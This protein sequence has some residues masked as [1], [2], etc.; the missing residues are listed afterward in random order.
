MNEEIRCVINKGK[1]GPRMNGKIMTPIFFQLYTLYIKKDIFSHTLLAILF[2]QSYV[3]CIANNKYLNKL[4]S[5][6]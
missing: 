4:I 2:K 1:V 3:S 6:V 5:E